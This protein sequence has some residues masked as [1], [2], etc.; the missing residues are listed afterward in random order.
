MSPPMAWTQILW[1]RWRPTAYAVAVV[2]VAVA[3]SWLIG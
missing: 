3:I 1:L 2:V